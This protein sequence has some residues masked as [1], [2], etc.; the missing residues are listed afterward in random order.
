MFS[1]TK[2]RQYSKV[3]KE[4]FL[5]L[6]LLKLTSFK[7]SVFLLNEDIIRKIWLNLRITTVVR[8]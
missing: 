3:Q 2:A 5:S 6:I 4:Y 1:N 8:G 7:T